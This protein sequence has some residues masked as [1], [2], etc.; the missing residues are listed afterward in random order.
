MALLCLSWVIIQGAQY[1]PEVVA[2][3]SKL[4]KMMGGGTVV[5]E[6]RLKGDDIYL[7]QKRRTQY[8][9]RVR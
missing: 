2:P 4:S 8:N 6:T 3:L 5:M 9:N 1:D 7:Q